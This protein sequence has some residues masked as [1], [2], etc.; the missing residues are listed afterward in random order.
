MTEAEVASLR[1]SGFQS[2]Q[3]RYL[4]NFGL[5]YRIS[6]NAIFGLGADYNLL[7]DENDVY[8]WRAIAD[9][10]VEL[11]PK[12]LAKSLSELASDDAVEV[13][14][15]PVQH[16]VVSLGVAGD[17][18]RERDVD[19]LPASDCE[20]NDVVENRRL[21]CVD[22]GVFHLLRGRALAP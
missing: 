3:S 8:G 7:E 10:I 18:R 13:L 17:F 4:T 21:P 9:V 1:S 2:D 12:K 16:G 19:D 22:A 15:H 5:R 14:E 6:D 11:E 20:L